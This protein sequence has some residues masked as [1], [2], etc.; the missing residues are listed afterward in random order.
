MIEVIAEIESSL[1][2]KKNKKILLNNDT[3]WERILLI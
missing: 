2:G 3:Q 1:T